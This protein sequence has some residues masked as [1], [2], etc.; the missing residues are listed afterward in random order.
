MNMSSTTST[1]SEDLESLL[2][3][4]DTDIDV[5]IETLLDMK[6]DV[7]Y[8]YSKN[9]YCRTAIRIQPLY[10]ALDHLLLK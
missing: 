5:A 3:R 2:R 9:N 4:T 7:W 1:F 8:Y 10:L 6:K